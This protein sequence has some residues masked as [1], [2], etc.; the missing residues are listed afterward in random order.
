MQ[1][2]EIY[3]PTPDGYNSEKEDNTSIDTND[4]RKTRL[5]LDRLNKLRVMNDVR[6]LEHE[7]K[8]D[9]VSG[10]YKQPAPAESG[11]PQQ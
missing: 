9:K 1:L 10:Q 4:T 8:L 2:L 5:T 6:K 7:K 11:L 3:E